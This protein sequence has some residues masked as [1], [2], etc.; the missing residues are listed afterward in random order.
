MYRKYIND[1]DQ[2]SICNRSLSDKLNIV[3]LKG[4][5]LCLISL[6]PIFDIEMQPR[7]I[8]F[9]PQTIGNDIRPRA[10]RPRPDIILNRLRRKYDIPNMHPDIKKCFGLIKHITYTTSCH[11]YTN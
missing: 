10:K 6:Q 2:H 4:T 7:Y 1:F 11:L 9:P 3:Q 8:K 5:I